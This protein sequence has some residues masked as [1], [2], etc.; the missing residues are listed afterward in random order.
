MAGCDFSVREYSYDDVDG[1]FNLT[2]FALVNED[3][4]YKVLLLFKF[5]H[6]F[7]IPLIKMAK[8]LTPNLKL[9][10]SPWAAPGWMKTDNKMD[11]E[12][13]LKGAIG[14]VYYQTWANY[15]VR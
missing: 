7:Q 5:N 13:M 12:G 6:F 14:G 3:L 10:S 15:F 11:G 9:F 1:D 8:A 4:N 2:N